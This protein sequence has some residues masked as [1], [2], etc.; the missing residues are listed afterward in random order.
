MKGVSYFPKGDRELT[1]LLKEF[2]GWQRVLDPSFN[3]S[4]EIY[5]G[6]E[7]AGYGP[8]TENKSSSDL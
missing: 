5:Q 2:G 8:V 6:F 1:K 7:A 4:E 3:P